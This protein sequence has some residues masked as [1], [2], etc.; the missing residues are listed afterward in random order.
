MSQE[1]A[2]VRTGRE[3]ASATIWDWRGERDDTAARASKARKG[4]VLRGVVGGA[5][6]ALFF[7]ALGRPIFGAVV[8]SIAGLTTGLGLA[9]P[10]GAY[11]ALDRVVL[12]AG[13]LV[14]AVLTW[15]LLTPVYFF[16]FAPF[17]WLFRRG[18]RDRLRRRFERDR[19]TYWDERDGE[20]PIDRP[21]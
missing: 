8:W 13:K 15:L 3:E 16:F 6:G 17:G 4:A 20:R 9:S 11:A 14:G 19:E 1:H 18:Q 12:G 10:L 7:F 5:A 21:Y 2:E